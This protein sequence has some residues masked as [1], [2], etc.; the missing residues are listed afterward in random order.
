M[1][2]VLEGKQ[3]RGGSKMVIYQENDLV[4]GGGVNIKKMKG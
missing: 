3:K 4:L 1:S 2:L